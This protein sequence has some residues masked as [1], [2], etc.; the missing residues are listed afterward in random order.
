MKATDRHKARVEALLSEPFEGCEQLD[1]CEDLEPTLADIYG[2]TSDTVRT[3]APAAAG[4]ISELVANKLKSNE[5]EDAKKKLEAG[6][7]FQSNKAAQEAE[8]KAALAEADASTEP[9]PN[10]P[11]H[12]AAAQS[13][14][15]ANAAR[16]KSN[17][18]AQQA[19]AANPQAM[20]PGGPGGYPGAYAP[21]AKDDTMKY[22]LIGGGVLAAVAVLALVLR[23]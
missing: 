23:K 13:R 16:Q 7:A 10:G 18:F 21:P 9:D 20:M 22:V 17:Y 19:M 14:T 4:V 5:E 15:L 2:A 11:M 1:G 8:K 3:V 12:R 6:D